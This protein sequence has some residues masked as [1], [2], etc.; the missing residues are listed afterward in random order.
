[1]SEGVTKITK[2]FKQPTLPGKYYRLSCL[3][4]KNKGFCYYL[5]G[6]RVVLG[7]GDKVDIQVLD[8]KSSREHAELVLV[9]TQFVLT[10]LGSQ[11]GVVVND[12]KVTQHQIKESDKIIIG[13]TVFKFD[14]IT[15]KESKDLA[16]VEDDE[17]EEYEEEEEETTKSKKKNAKKNEQKKKPL[18]MIA[19]V[20]LAVVFLLPDEKVVKPGD[21]KNNPNNIGAQDVITDLIDKKQKEEDRELREKLDTYIQRGLREYREGNYFRAIEEFNLA[22]IL[23]PSNGDANFY[24]NRTKQKLDNLI[25]LIFLKAKQEAEALK[26]SGALISYCEILRLLQDYPEDKRFIDAK[27]NIEFLESQMGMEKNEYQCF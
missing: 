15:V 1:M 19:I 23:S 13:Q 10:D 27:K 3:T 2:N 8:A 12:L 17:V 21:N 25:E 4:G 22:L 20:L 6:K 7:R 14:T 9:G 18:V 5:T 26:Y 24:L 11:N 16:V